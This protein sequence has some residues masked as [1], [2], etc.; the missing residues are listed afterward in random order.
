MRLSVTTMIKNPTGFVW[1]PCEYRPNP[2][3]SDEEVIAEICSILAIDGVV[4]MV[5]LETERNEAGGPRRIVGRYPI[6]LS[7]QLIGAIS[8]LHTP[9]VE[10]DAPNDQ[11][12]I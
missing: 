3:H 4:R 6:I 8:P 1:W 9:L 2:R 11:P 7:K 12:A 5:K 10:M